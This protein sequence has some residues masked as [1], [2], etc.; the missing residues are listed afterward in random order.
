M[1]LNGLLLLGLNFIAYSIVNPGPRGSKRLGYVLIVTALLTFVIQQE[2][3]VLGALGFPAD[4]I[5]QILIAGF[6]MPFF[7]IPLVFYRIRKNAAEKKAAA[8][9]NN[10][11]RPDDHEHH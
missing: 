6:M 7:L 3:R 1:F 2:F 10:P 9:R 5:R 11:P 4:R 8:P